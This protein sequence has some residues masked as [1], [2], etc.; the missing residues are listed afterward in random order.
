MKSRE[1]T[2]TVRGELKAP[3]EKAASLTAEELTEIAGGSGLTIGDGADEA[4][5]SG[6]AESS[7]GRIGFR[8]KPVWD[9]LD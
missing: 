8:R 5:K 3:D 9:H 4:P 2:D 1:E 6:A 7:D